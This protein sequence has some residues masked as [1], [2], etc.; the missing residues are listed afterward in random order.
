MNDILIFNEDSTKH[1]LHVQRILERFKNYELY[2]NLKKCEFDIDEVDF[3]DFII[4]IKRI[5]MD[6]KRIQ[7]I[8]KWFKFKTYREMQIFL[9][10]INFYRRFIYRYFKI[11]ASLTSLLKDNKNEKK[12]DFFVWSK[13]VEQTFRQFCDIFMS[14]FLF[15]HYDFFK[16]IRMKIDVFNFAVANIF[17]QQNENENWRSMTFWS[18]KMILAKQNYEIYDQKFLI[19]IVAFKQW[20]HYLKSNFYLIKMLSDHNNLK[21][22]MTKKKLNF[23]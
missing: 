12:K 23:K 13:S 11:I 9:R 19:I 3:L 7:M 18:R 15:I 20:R 5:R 2:I 10:F 6:S 17:S 22:L 1:R 16:K 14:I 8:K 21:K 4:F